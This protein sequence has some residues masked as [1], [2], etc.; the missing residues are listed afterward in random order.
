MPVQMLGAVW[1]AGADFVP[2]W[3]A[4]LGNGN[5]IGG[6]LGAVLLPV[7]GFGKFLLV[8]LSLTTPSQC[9]PAM[10]AMLNSFMSL[11]PVLAKIPRP[12]LAIVSAAM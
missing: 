3:K 8:L 11:A 2:A 4:G 9:A 1:T 10:Y 12:L 5:D 6:L 7:G